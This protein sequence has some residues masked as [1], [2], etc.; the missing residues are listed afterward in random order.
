MAHEQIA[1]AEYMCN[2]DE[3]T[4]G[5]ARKHITE[6]LFLMNELVPVGHLKTASLFSVNALI[7][8]EIAIDKM[9][10]GILEPELLIECEDLLT[11]ALAYTVSV[12]GENNP[13]SAKILGNLGRLYESLLNYDVSTTIKYDYFTFLDRIEEIRID[14]NISYINHS[15]LCIIFM[16]NR[17]LC[18][19]LRK[20]FKSKRK[21]WVKMTM[22]LVGPCHNWPVL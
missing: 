5:M 2:Y 10:E 18:A 22:K 7:C 9:A 4:F 15:L 21:R 12:L 8:E 17:N 6:A 16:C 1:Y 13:Q 3:G 11:K 14:L 19:C 20:P